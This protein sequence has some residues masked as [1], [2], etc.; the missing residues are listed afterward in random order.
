MSQNHQICY[1]SLAIDRPLQNSWAEFRRTRIFTIQKNQ[2]AR[3]WPCLCFSSSK[4][5]VFLK[6]PTIIL[7]QK[8]S[9]LDTQG[10]IKTQINFRRYGRCQTSEKNSECLNFAMTLDD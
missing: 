9:Y 3:L 2:N 6:I 4:L 7:G 8:R 10:G 5:D 1:I